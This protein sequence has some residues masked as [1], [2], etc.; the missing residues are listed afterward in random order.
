MAQQHID[1]RR[2][3]A[4]DVGLVLAD[5]VRGDLLS[6]VEPWVDEG[7]IAECVIQFA[8]IIVEAQG[9]ALAWRNS[10]PTGPDLSPLLAQF[11][12]DHE[13]ESFILSFPYFTPAAAGQRYVRQRAAFLRRL[14]GCASALLDDSPQGGYEIHAA[15]F[16]TFLECCPAGLAC[17]L[18]L[19]DTALRYVDVLPTASVRP[20]LTDL[21]QRISAVDSIRQSP[22]QPRQLEREFVVR[23]L[24][25]LAERFEVPTVL[26]PIDSRGSRPDAP[27]YDLCRLAISVLGQRERPGAI[28]EDGP[29]PYDLLPLICRSLDQLSTT[30]DGEPPCRD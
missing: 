30:I 3:G 11:I 19:D 18:H 17:V 29:V 20:L 21:R 5:G 22:G 2:F 9:H 26:P 15:A 10:V 7:C 24:Y 4:V 28:P 25:R 6:I 14:D 23:D 27:L 12:P 1:E 8:L 13:R 16:M